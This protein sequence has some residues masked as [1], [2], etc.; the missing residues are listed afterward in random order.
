MAEGPRRYGDAE[1]ARLLERATELQVRRGGGS[2]EGLT[3]EELRDVAR[4]AGID[5]EMISA[6]AAELDEEDGS[7]R[8][9]PAVGLPRGAGPGARHGRGGG[10]DSAEPKAIFG[11]PSAWVEAVDLP[12]R[13]GEDDLD[14]LVRR[15]EAE[16]RQRGSEVRTAGVAQWT[17][18]TRGEG[19]TLF[20]VE[21]LP[22]GS[23]LRLT[24]DRHEQAQ[25][26][27][28]ALPGLG[29]V[30]GGFLGMITGD[31]AVG[32]PV[33]AAGGLVG[34][35]LG[36]V[37]W[38]LAAR[39]WRTRVD[40]LMGGLVG[41]AVRHGASIENPHAGGGTRGALPEGDAS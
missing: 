32:L 7:P 20:Q 30:A 18:A 12:V 4:E 10:G 25:G 6:A 33:A 36:R 11:E 1:V 39:R 34:H 27:H 23:R 40:T 19:T 21:P 2:G 15:L 16:L 13:L 8:R 14:R 22:H 31:P 29:V 37:A 26:L 41:D 24:F 5:P 3:L 17:A 28:A 35:L 38:H 9:L